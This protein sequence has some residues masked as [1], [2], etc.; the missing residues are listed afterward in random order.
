MCPSELMK[1]KGSNAEGAQC[2]N[3]RPT[4]IGRGNEGK[5][6]HGGCQGGH[7]GVE[8]SQGAWLDDGDCHDGGCDCWR[9]M[10]MKQNI[11]SVAVGICDGESDAF[12]I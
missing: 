12:M 9:D 3:D 6:S 4:D 10:Y 11:K 5:P 8:L 2:G 7:I 1:A